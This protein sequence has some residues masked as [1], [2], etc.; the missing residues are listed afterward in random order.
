MSLGLVMFAKAI[1]LL[2]WAFI[3]EWFW[4]EKPAELLPAEQET[5]PAATYSPLCLP[6]PKDTTSLL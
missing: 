6:A 2:A 5:R 1:V 3:S 4:P